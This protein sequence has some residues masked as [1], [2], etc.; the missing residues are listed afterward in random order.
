MS[1]EIFWGTA[2]FLDPAVIMPFSRVRQVRNPLVKV[3]HKYS[4]SCI[5]SIDHFYLFFHLLW[6][7]NRSNPSLLGTIPPF[8][9]LGSQHSSSGGVPPLASLSFPSFLHLTVPPRLA[10]YFPI[11]SHIWWAF[12]RVSLSGV[13]HHVLWVEFLPW[14]CLQFPPN[15]VENRH[16][17]KFCKINFHFF[18]FRNG[19]RICTQNYFFFQKYLLSFQIFA[20]IYD[21]KFW[22]FRFKIF[23]PAFWK[24]FR[25]ISSHS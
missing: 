22:N 2:H 14:P 12:V 18:P 4:C 11:S 3:L 9:G 15:L 24:L 20:L 5:G 13:P 17:P 10:L 8:L 23:F 7:G 16:W 6:M 1:F 19:M 21:G 25:I